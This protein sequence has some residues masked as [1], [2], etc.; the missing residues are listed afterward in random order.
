MKELV[1]IYDAF[2]DREKRDKYAK[3]IE[4]VKKNAELDR[5]ERKAAQM[6]GLS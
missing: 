6:P 1:E 4:I 2:G 3:K 5:E